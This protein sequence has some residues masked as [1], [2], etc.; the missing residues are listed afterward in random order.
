MPG[1]YSRHTAALPDRLDGPDDRIG[2]EQPQVVAE[3]SDG[4]LAPYAPV[5]IYTDIPRAWGAHRTAKA[6]PMGAM[7][8]SRRTSLPSKRK[9]PQLLP[10]HTY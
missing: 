10:I 6:M 4:I 3:H 2:T 8:A 9:L 5:K 7:R 1:Y